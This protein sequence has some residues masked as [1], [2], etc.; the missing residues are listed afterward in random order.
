LTGKTASRYDRCAVTNTCPLAVE[1]YSANEYW[2]KAASL[3]HTDPTGTK[4]LPDS[5]FARNYFMASHQHGAGN[6]TTKGNCQQFQNPLDSAPVQ[7]ALFIALDEWSTVGTEPPPSQVPRL[8]DGTL[9]P[10]LPQKG[11]GFPNIPGVVYNGLKTTRYLFNYGPNFYATG[12][13]T[14]NPP[15]LSAPYQDNPANGPIYPSFVPRT[16]A[17]GN[18]IAGIRLPDVTVP[19]ATYTGWALR[20]GAAAGD[21]CEAA[22]QSIPF[23]KTKAERVANGDPRLSIEERY[24]SLAAYSEAVTKAIEALVARR[25]MLREDAQA[26]V[27]RLLRLAQA[28]GALK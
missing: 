27:D 16:D 28:T 26:N 21:G 19:L 3:L 18:D 10:P 9:V 22:G 7:R 24:P 2:V 5:P 8:S 13:P 15:V 1:I 11:V 6:R 20:A 12:I 14:I 25:L 23:A 17:D 4:D